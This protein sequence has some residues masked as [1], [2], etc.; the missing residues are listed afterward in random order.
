MKSRGTGYRVEPRFSI[1]TLLWLIT[2]SA[3]FLA[4]R[5]T[6]YPEVKRSKAR[7]AVL[8]DQVELLHAQNERLQ[9]VT[10]SGC[11]SLQPASSE[12]SDLG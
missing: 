5:A 9:V 3:M 12:E 10:P 4:G 1:L 2:A 7:E 11:C 8:K 6:S